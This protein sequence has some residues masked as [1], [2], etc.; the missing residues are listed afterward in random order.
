MLFP[1]YG[2]VP[3]L[4]VGFALTKVSRKQQNGKNARSQVFTFQ[5]QF[6]SFRMP[7]HAQDTEKDVKRRP[8][9]QRCPS[10]T[11]RKKKQWK[12][13]DC[14]LKIV[15]CVKLLCIITHVKYRSCL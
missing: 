1:R 15:F 12:I 4:S 8:D 6:H 3:S 11:F 14:N 10:S 2:L 5:L 7:C 9:S 13:V